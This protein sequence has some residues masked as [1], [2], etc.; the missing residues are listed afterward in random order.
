MKS[1]EENITKALDAI[2][3]DM[4]NLKEGKSDQKYNQLLKKTKFVKNTQLIARLNQAI[5][6]KTEECLQLEQEVLRQKG[7][8]HSMKY[9]CKYED[10]HSCKDYQGFE[11]Q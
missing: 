2:K 4:K 3:N 10:Y 9:D 5:K 1:S 6:N 7:I 8:I 11:G